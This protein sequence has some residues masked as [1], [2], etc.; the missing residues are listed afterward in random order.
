METL[1]L[2]IYQYAGYPLGVLIGF[3]WILV[4]KALWKYLHTDSEKQTIEMPKIFKT[5]PPE[6]TAEEIKYKTILDNI[7]NYGTSK[8]QQ[9]VR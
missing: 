8:P 4:I 1:N 3:T 5:K 9:R 2:I 7:D 6:P